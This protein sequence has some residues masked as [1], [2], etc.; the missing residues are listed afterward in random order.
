MGRKRK[1]PAISLPKI[2]QLPSGAYH[3]RVL[4]DGRRVSITKETYDECVA[5]YLALKNKITKAKESQFGKAVTLET[6]VRNYIAARDGFCSPSTIRRLH[7]QGKSA[8]YIKNGWMFFSSCLKAAGATPPE[9]MLYPPDNKEPAYL[10]PEEIDKFV[11]AIKGHRFEIPFLMCLSSLRRSELLAMDWKNIDL[12]HQVMRVRGAAVV[13][14]DGLV[15][16]QQTKTKKSRRSI[17]IIPPLLEALKKEQ[18]QTGKIVKVNA[19]TIYNDLQKVCAAAGITIVNLHGLRH[20]FA[21]LA[22]YLQ[23][24]EM[25]A[26]EIGG[27]ND[28][29]TM[30]KIYTHL[31][32]RDIAKRCQDFCNYF[33]PEAMKKRQIGNT[34]GNDISKTL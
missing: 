33:S 32:Q 24:P 22:Y 16:K 6:A 7:E 4:I 31:A 28:L 13:G 21:S 5:E 27:W 10:E 15:E 9:V 12:G 20:S 18:R 3:T 23:I 25:I 17:P 26:A 11:E 14:P 8:K 2:E 19:D 1:E 29:S 30:H 34:V